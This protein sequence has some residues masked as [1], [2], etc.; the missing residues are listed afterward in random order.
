MEGWFG[1]AVVVFQH[2]MMV[3]SWFS[4]HCDIV[5]G[6]WCFQCAVT[7]WKGGAVVVVVFDALQCGEFTM[8]KVG[9]GGREEAV[10]G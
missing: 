9:G 5:E 10:V 1:V 7:L 8:L 2:V 6:W 4:T 3:V